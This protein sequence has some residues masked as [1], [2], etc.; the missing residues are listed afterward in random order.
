MKPYAILPLLLLMLLSGCKGKIF[1]SQEFTRCEQTFMDYLSAVKQISLLG[2]AFGGRGTILEPSEVSMQDYEVLAAV[3]AKDSLDILTN[4]VLAVYERSLKSE[5]EWRDACKKNF[6]KGVRQYYEKREYARK[7]LKELQNG[8]RR[9]MW[10]TERQYEELL[11]KP[12]LTV[13]QLQEE[14]LKDRFGQYSRYVE[15]KNKVD[16]LINRKDEIL[17]EWAAKMYPQAKRYQAM[18]PETVLAKKVCIVFTVGEDKEQK[19]VT[20]TFNPDLTKI[21]MDPVN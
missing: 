12:E 17:V 15:A 19:D 21:Y 14:A 13:E 16:D 20:L 6:D 2:R 10:E 18:P 11:A 1:K 7:R 9:N 4:S 3:T 8:A 5:T